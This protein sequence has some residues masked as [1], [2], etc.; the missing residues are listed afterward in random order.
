VSS[1]PEENELVSTAFGGNHLEINKTQSG[2]VVLGS[3][4]QIYALGIR[5]D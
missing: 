5:D 2:D 1:V 3:Q 4:L